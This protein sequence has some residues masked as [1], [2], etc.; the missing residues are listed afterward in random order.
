MRRYLLIASGGSEMSEQHA[1]T[2]L[3]RTALART[4]LAR[5]ALARTA[6]GGAA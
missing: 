2:A 4:A 5:T 1:R 3:A 6:L